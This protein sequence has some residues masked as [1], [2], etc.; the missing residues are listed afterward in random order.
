MVRVVAGVTAVAP[1]GIMAVQAVTLR[2]PTTD[3]LVVTGVSGVVMVVPVARGMGGMDTRHGAVPG[4]VEVVRRSGTVPG[5]GPRRSG[6]IRVA[7]SALVVLAIRI[8]H[9][10]LLVERTSQLY[11]H[12]VST[13]TLR[14]EA[15]S[16]SAGS[17]TDVGG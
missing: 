8:V 15:H 17:V 16:R 12:G 7:D 1:L 4:M 10:G 6:G 13:S 5:V 3:G 9:G 2:P 14:R 11:P